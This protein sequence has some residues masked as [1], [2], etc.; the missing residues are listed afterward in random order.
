M[1]LFRTGGGG[2]SSSLGPGPDAV[3]SASGAGKFDLAPPNL[4]NPFGALGDAADSVSSLVGG[5][6][7]LIGSIGVPN[8]D[9]NLGGALRIPTDAAANLAGAA[10]NVL[11]A[12]GG[13]KLPYLGNDPTRTGAT[14]G[15]IPGE[16][17]KVI[18]FPEQA[19]EGAVASIRA[20]NRIGLSENEQHM[21][22]NGAS[23]DLVAKEML[24]RG[25]GFVD[26]PV[27]NLAGSIFLDPTTYLGGAVFK[28]VE[29]LGVGEHAVQAAVKAGVAESIGTG[30][31]EV[32]GHAI[33]AGGQRALDQMAGEAMY[34]IIDSVGSKH[35]NNLVRLA[36]EVSPEYGQSLMRGFSDTAAQYIPEV[37]KNHLMQEAGVRQGDQVLRNTAELTGGKVRQYA[38]GMLVMGKD[39]VRRD[40]MTLADRVAPTF[41]EVRGTAERKALAA[42]LLQRATGMDAVDA[43]AIIDKAVGKGAPD[44]QML[45]TLHAGA[46]GRFG[47]AVDTVMENMT[48]EEWKA[49]G[50]T[51]RMTAMA[52]DTLSHEDGKGLQQALAAGYKRTSAAGKELFHRGAPARKAPEAEH[53][54]YAAAKEAAVTAARAAVNRYS[55]FSDL[56]GIV[57]DDLL[58]QKVRDRVQGY[59]SGNL[60]PRELRPAAEGTGAARKTSD[61]LPQAIKNLLDTQGD[62]GYRLGFQPEGDQTVIS[63]FA[64]DELVKPFVP[65]ATDVPNLSIKPPIVRAFEGATR[66]IQYSKIIN[67]ARLSLIEGGAQHGATEHEMGQFFNGVVNAAT[68]LGI[69]VRGL[70]QTAYKEGTK[71]MA[72]YEAIAADA[73]GLPRLEAFKAQGGDLTSLVMKA[74]E[75]NWKEVGITQKIS[76]KAK[77]MFPTVVPGIAEDIYPKFRFRYDPIFLQQERIESPFLG[78]LRGVKPIYTEAGAKAAMADGKRLYPLVVQDATANGG[79]ANVLDAG[80]EF[81]AIQGR[82]ATGGALARNRLGGILNS[83]MP[84]AKDII[85]RKTANMV[86]QVITEHPDAFKE[87]LDDINP[88]LWTIMEHEYG[89]VG[90][91]AATT[92]AYIEERWA[93]QT[94]EKVA[95]VIDAAKPAFDSGMGSEMKAFLDA[96]KAWQQGVRDWIKANPGKGLAAAAEDP[97]IAALRDARTAAAADLPARAAE[98]VPAEPLKVEVKTNPHIVS[99]ADE[100]TIWQAYR[101]SMLRSY[102]QAHTTHYFASSRNFV[103]RSINHPYL[104]LYPFSYMMKVG[105]EYARFLLARPFGL[106]APLAGYAAA[107]HVQRQIIEQEQ[108][109]PENFGQFMKD[110]AAALYLFDILLPG[111]P[112]DLPA[113]APATVRHAADMQNSGQGFDLNAFAANSP[114]DA[115]GNIGIGRDV[116]AVFGSSTRQG[117][118]GNIAGDIA[119]LLDVAQKQFDGIF[120]GPSHQP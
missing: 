41:A 91:V 116:S 6:A 119:G 82:A 115:F 73:W 95:E 29:A 36:S 93:L 85:D 61:R 32:A 96:D 44:M 70:P 31:Y 99:S 48:P 24:G 54:A 25:A 5:V 28:G 88:S 16:M 104:G 51:R 58:V 113:N 68:D 86:Q 103:E 84:N 23:P 72:S 4:D 42:D 120:G 3:G 11:G 22:D 77:T 43:V 46:Y 81:L 106:K 75:G 90:D 12:V 33:P 40:V 69:G 38:G 79:I 37:A 101:E 87:L 71:I 83:V 105:R 80:A 30:I 15:D 67:T 35:I 27:A 64:G 60:L 74:F 57:S 1:S 45:R 94:P 114:A 76:G 7:G 39:R 59:V 100:E 56:R 118:V 107:A 97:G 109:D 89:T 47:R 49:F 112:T 108:Y 14:L 111:L 65:F 19:I 98:Q 20:Q 9:I 13:I 18:S 66:G 92:R 63:T 21:L 26:N 2:P 8:S 117:A 17:G 110:N 102:D 55:L 52:Y 62:H 34:G 53:A 10:G 78:A 50:T